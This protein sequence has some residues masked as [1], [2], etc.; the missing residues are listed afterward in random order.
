MFHF[1]ERKLGILFSN[2]NVAVKDHLGSSPEGTTVYG[3][4]DWF[5]EGVSSR[6]RTEAV[7]HGEQSL[8]IV[9]DLGADT[10][11]VPPN[12]SEGSH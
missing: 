5:V 6:D 4:D 10:S 2:D 12:P 9:G 1:R 3:R 7:R 8:L 11:I